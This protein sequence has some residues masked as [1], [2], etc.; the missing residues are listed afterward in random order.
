MAHDRGDRRRGHAGTVVDVGANAGLMSV[1]AAAA[2]AEVIAF[3]PV[4]RSRAWTLDNLAR[5]AL[6][7]KV[8]LRP[9]A[10]SDS[11]GVASF[12]IPAG[13]APSSASLGSEGFRGLDGEVVEVEVT[14]LDAAGL[15]GEIALI[16]VDVEGHEHE[17]LR[18]AERTIEQSRPQLILEV[19]HD[20]P[21]RAIDEWLAAHDY[22]AQ[23]LDGSARWVTSV[24]TLRSDRFRNLWCMPVE[25]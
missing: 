4:P 10:V 13:G 20:G 25:R 21:W 8:D 5:N 3:E 1:V 18:G 16:K 6:T 9:Q 2:G 17:V 24:R 15:P 12:H 22:R 7:D 23:R 14:T 19:N 11:T